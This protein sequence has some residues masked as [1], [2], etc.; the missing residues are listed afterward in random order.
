MNNLINKYANKSL[1]EITEGDSLRRNLLLG[2]GFIITNPGN[3]LQ[4]KA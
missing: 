3:K 1:A 4:F 2:F